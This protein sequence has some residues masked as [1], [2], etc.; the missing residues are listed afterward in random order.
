VP[1]KPVGLCG[2]RAQERR[3]KASWAGAGIRPK[4]PKRER[5]RVQILF[6]FESFYKLYTN[7]NPNQI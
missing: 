4:K 5:E 1:G 6:I 2:P 3:E 7:L